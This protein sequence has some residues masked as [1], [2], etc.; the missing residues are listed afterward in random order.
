MVFERHKQLLALL[1]ALGG[2]IGNLD[3]QK[4]LFLYCSEI[5]HKPTYEFIPYR[6]G[7]FSFTSYDDKRRLVKEGLLEDQS[8][9]WVLT[10]EGRGLGTVRPVVRMK[11]D[12]FAKNFECL[13]GEALVAEAYRRHPF[14]A[15]RSEIAEKILAGDN[16]A[17]AAIASVRPQRG[18]PGI[19]TIGY[20]KRSLESYLNHLLK[21][22]VSLLCDVRRN[23][24]SHKYGFSKNTL[25]KGCEAIGI[26]YEHLSELGMSS[27]K[28]QTLNTQEDYDALF[29]VYEREM[30]PQQTPALEQ[31]RNWVNAGER[32]ALTCFELLP[33][34][35]HRHCVAK[36]L[37]RRWGEPLKPSHL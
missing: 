25:R 34:Q 27:D 8:R 32:V 31:I 21:N 7:G 13:R 2:N 22:G 29:A 33:H 18:E 11:M 19:V 17:L 26:R 23:A 5:E 30:L 28:R 15:A 12:K 14:F 3:F 24:F 36:E 4:L 6:F 20:E 10:A 35:C 37:H 16:L 9:A 1:D